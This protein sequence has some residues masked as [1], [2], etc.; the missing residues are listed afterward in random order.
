M[1]RPTF[2]RLIAFALG[3]VAL[4]ASCTGGAA[5]MAK[6]LRTAFITPETGFDPAASSDLYSASMQRAIFDTLYGFEYLTRPCI[7]TSTRAD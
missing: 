5:D 4:G 2:R 6:T 1:T 7:W 3:V